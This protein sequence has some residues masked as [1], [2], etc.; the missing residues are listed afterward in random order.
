MWRSG[1]VIK[2][3]NIGMLLVVDNGGAMRLQIMFEKIS[4]A[5]ATSDEPITAEHQ[6]L[7]EPQLLLTLLHF[8]HTRLARLEISFLI[9]AAINYHSPEMNVFIRTQFCMIRQ[10]RF[11]HFVINFHQHFRRIS[12]FI[13]PDGF[14]SSF[15]L[16]RYFCGGA[17]FLVFSKID[18]IHL[19]HPSRSC[20]C[21]IKITGWCHF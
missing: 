6:H 2:R 17:P 7:W 21:F 18:L 19:Q 4:T 5:T 1:D 20:C 8:W 14:D 9:L 12:W 15:W 16:F 11:T 3:S 13:L 10:K